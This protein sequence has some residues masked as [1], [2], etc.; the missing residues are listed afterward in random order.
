MWIECNPNPYGKKTGDCAVRA[1]AL[2]LHKDWNEAY[3]MLCAKGFERGEL[4]NADSV[5]GEVL[6]DNGFERHICPDCGTAEDFAKAHP[7]GVYVLGF[8]G[9][10]ATIRDGNILDAWDSS[11]EVP[12][13]Y[14]VK[15]E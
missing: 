4:P 1:I 14:Y 2:A 15:G 8:G 7:E 11:K 10:V 3:A 13:F 9:H 6:K 5:W 12:Q